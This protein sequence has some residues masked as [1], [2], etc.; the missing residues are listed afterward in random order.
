MSW[1]GVGT[2]L[3]TPFTNDGALDEAAVR[4]LAKRQV[5]AGIHFLVPCGT[6]GEVPTL[7]PDERRRVVEIVAR[8]G[9]GTE[10]A[11]AR[12]R[13]RLRHPRGDSLG[14][15]VAEAGRS[16]HPLGDALLQPP[17]ARRALSALQGH[18]R[19]H[20]AADHRLQRARPDGLQHRS[21][22]ARPPRR[23]PEH[24]RR[25]G[26]VGQHHADGRDLP[27]RARRF[28]R[29]VGRRCDHAAADGA[30][31]PGHHLGRVERSAGRDGANGRDG[32]RRATSPPRGRCTRSCCR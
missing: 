23:H 5:D 8:G 29:P 16:G 20:V 18:R 32:R 22:H 27:R 3:I 26:S 25:E 24:R 21:G 13:R 19:Q 17:D 11:G 28:R 7:T 10:R 12:R 4:R 31:R 2:A 1:T 14:G 6:T 9:Q 15:R 30:G